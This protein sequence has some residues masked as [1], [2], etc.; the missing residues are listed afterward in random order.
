MLITL[1]APIASIIPP[2]TIAHII[3]HMVPNMPSIPPEINR[4]LS[5]A[6]LVF[7]W[8]ETDIASKIALYA[9]LEFKVLDCYVQRI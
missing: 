5:I 8:V 3:N 6:L 7:T 1:S 4:S 9:I 2:K